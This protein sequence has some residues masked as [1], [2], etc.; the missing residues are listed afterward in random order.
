MQ[1]RSKP[2]APQKARLVYLWLGALLGVVHLSAC[3]T[4]HAPSANAASEKNASVPRKQDAASHDEPGEEEANQSRDSEHDSEEPTDQNEEHADH[5]KEGE[6]KSKHRKRYANQGNE[7]VNLAVS[8][9]QAIHD[10][11]SRRANPGMALARRPDAVKRAQEQLTHDYRERLASLQEQ[12]LELRR[13][14]RALSSA[15][16][17]LMS[18]LDQISAL[19]DRLQ[20]ELGIGKARREYRGQ[21]IKSLAALI[22]TM[23]PQ[24]GARILSNMSEADAQDI[25]LGMAQKSERKAAK[26]LAQMPPN[27]AA[28][29]GKRYLAADKHIK[30]SDGLIHQGSQDASKRGKAP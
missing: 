8:A 16:K 25:V 24:S 10:A 7:P 30:G 13:R 1:R 17:D 9:K 21:R 15:T 4:A 2:R 20:R 3:L 23:P 28:D 18:K 27:K 19:E 11:G 29:L 12:N 22:M 5:E 26:I 6:H 14:D